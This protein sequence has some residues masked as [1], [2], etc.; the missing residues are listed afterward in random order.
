MSI[1]RRP[2]DWNNYDQ[3]HAEG[4]SDKEFALSIGM[5]PNNFAQH[6]RRH[7]R[8]ARDTADVPVDGDTDPA[9][10]NGNL[11]AI[12]AAHSIAPQRTSA[13]PAHY[14]ASAFDELRARVVT[15]ESFV[16]ALQAQQRPSASERTDSASAHPDALERIQEALV[17]LD[18]RLHVVEASQERSALPAHSDAPA[19]RIA[20]ER[21]NPPRWIN[22]GMHIAADMADF[23][24]IY[25]D[26][27][28]LEK[29][30]VVDL[31]LRTF[32]ALVREGDRADA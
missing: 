12:P 31:A 11:P 22:R 29:R 13:L 2:I 32:R 24:E 15:L 20:P 28:R 10:S 17:Q 27:H 6:K 4:L 7:L 9:E 14:D 1:P 19:H 30:E 21:T 18:T 23:I 5:D 3:C 25:A 26:E 8:H 16:A